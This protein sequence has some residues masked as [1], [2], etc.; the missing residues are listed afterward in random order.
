MVETAATSQTAS[1][2]YSAIG[3]MLDRLEAEDHPAYLTII[4]SAF[5][6]SWDSEVWF[7]KYSST[8]M[9]PDF[10]GG[11]RGDIVLIGFNTIER[12][13][14]GSL[15][16]TLVEVY[17][18]LSVCYGLSK[19]NLGPELEVPKQ[20]T[21]QSV[22]ILRRCIFIPNDPDETS[23]QRSL[24]TRIVN[25]LYGEIQCAVGWLKN[26]APEILRMNLER[27]DDMTIFSDLLESDQ[28]ESYGLSH[29]DDIDL[30]ERKKKPPISTD[31]LEQSTLAEVFLIPAMKLLVSLADSKLLQ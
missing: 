30:Q 12:L 14:E 1:A 25:V 26:N 5:F 31:A 15:P 10:S 22:R 23:H 9:P 20:Q 7:S 18:F 6:R 8:R 11:L 21:L 24:F 16:K 28:V 13:L 2:F 27:L 4:E 29:S 3:Q 19:V 17:S